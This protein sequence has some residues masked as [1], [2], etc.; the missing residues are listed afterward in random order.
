MLDMPRVSKDFRE[1]D[2]EISRLQQELRVNVH[3]FSTDFDNMFSTYIPLRVP[4]GSN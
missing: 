4:T 3:T 1:R 2:A